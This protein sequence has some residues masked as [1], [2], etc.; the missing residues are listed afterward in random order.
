MRSAAVITVVLVLAGVAHAHDVVTTLVEDQVITLP[1]GT[2]VVLADDHDGRGIELWISGR[3]IVR[4]GHHRSVQVNAFRIT[5]VAYNLDGDRAQ[6]KISGPPLRAPAKRRSRSPVVDRPKPREHNK[7][8]Q[9]SAESEEKPKRR[10]KLDETPVR[11][12]SRTDKDNGRRRQ[13]RG[14]PSGEALPRTEPP[15]PPPETVMAMAEKSLNE[16]KHNR[17]EYAL[18]VKL[19]KTIPLEARKRYYVVVG[20]YAHRLALLHWED[21]ELDK[22]V[23]TAFAKAQRQPGHLDHL[24]VCPSLWT[25]GAVASWQAAVEHAKGAST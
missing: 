10:A 9:H 22:Q 14:G 20:L 21:R 16:G 13:E 4:V 8:R 12:R 17:N 3:G 24:G 5:C 2:K 7:E 25:P 11:D 23:R 18:L 1:D 6:I 19:E 15:D